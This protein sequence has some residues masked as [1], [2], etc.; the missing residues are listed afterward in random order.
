M[1][2]DIDHPGAL[3]EQFMA[4]TAQPVSGA[5]SERRYQALIAFDYE[6]E[7]EIIY[8][9]NLIGV[10]DLTKYDATLLI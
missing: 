10:L 3:S 9:C 2:S 5:T 7:I 1:K 6:I 8:S 4:P